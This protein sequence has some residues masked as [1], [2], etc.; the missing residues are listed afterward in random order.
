LFSGEVKREIRILGISTYDDQRKTQIIGVIFRGSHWLDGIIKGSSSGEKLTNSIKRMII[1]SKHFPQIRVTV[2]SEDDLPKTS[3][4]DFA[5]LSKEIGK[6]V[7]SLSNLRESGGHRYRDIYFNSFS[8]GENKAK[9]VLRKTSSYSDI[10]EAL[11]IAMLITERMSSNP[12]QP[13][14]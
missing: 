8:I 10:P 4:V 14:N 5:N 2:L 7:I 1:E 11:R 6:P 3:Y 13:L 9:E 12:P